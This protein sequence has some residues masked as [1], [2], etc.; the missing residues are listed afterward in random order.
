MSEQQN[1]VEFNVVRVYTKDLTYVFDDAAAAAISQNS[2]PEELQAAT[3]VGFAVDV[4]VND[5]QQEDL[6]EVNVLLNLQIG[7]Q[8]R[9]TAKFEVV[10]SAIYVCRNLPEEVRAQALY[11][12]AAATLWPYITNTLDKFLTRSGIPPMYLNTQDFRSI[13]QQT[14]AQ[15]QMN[16]VAQ[17]AGNEQVA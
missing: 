4:Q 15:R 13:F 1:P 5:L 6:V 12:D 14:L 16:A 3:Q 11:F 8:A 7:D 10:Q 17:E 9:P 2:S